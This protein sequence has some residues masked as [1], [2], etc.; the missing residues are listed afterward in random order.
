MELNRFGRLPKVSRKRSRQSNHQ[1]LRRTGVYPAFHGMVLLLIS[2]YQVNVAKGL[3][4]V[5]YY[6]TGL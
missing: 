1:G 3:L 5:P 4:N 2:Y 6:K